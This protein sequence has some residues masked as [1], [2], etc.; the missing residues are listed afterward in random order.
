MMSRWVFHV[1]AAGLPFNMHCPK[2]RLKCKSILIYGS[3]Y[4]FFTYILQ[5]VCPNRKEGKRASSAGKVEIHKLQ[6]SAPVGIYLW[7]KHLWAPLILI[8]LTPFN[9]AH[10][11]SPFDG[12]KRILLTRKKPHQSSD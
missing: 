9:N 12:A 2:R 6:Q 3:C 11:R 7:L 4:N 5:E 10:Q 8:V 1:N